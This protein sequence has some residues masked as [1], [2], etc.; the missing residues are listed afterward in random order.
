MGLGVGQD[1]SALAGGDL[2]VGVE[3]ED[4]E[5]AEGANATLMKFSADGFAGV[6]DDHQIVSR[7]EVAQNEHVCRDAE[8]MDDEDCASSRSEDGFNS[9]GSEVEGD[10]INIGE[11]GRGADLKDGVGDSDE[12]E[13]WD[14]D[15]VAFADAE[16]E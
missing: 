11:D 1:G 9:I 7:G 16:S 5:I 4:G 15:F 6:F 2:L 8:G 10:R 14:D 13:G 12:G 3:A